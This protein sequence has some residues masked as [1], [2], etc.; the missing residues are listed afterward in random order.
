MFVFFSYSWGTVKI[1]EILYDPEGSDSD[2]EWIEFYNNS[3]SAISLKSWKIYLGG[4]S[5]ALAY[6]FPEVS[7]KA[8]GF[9]VVGFPDFCD[10]QENFAFQ[11][12]GSATDGV[13][14]E[15]SAGV[16]RDVLLYDSPNSNSLAIEDGSIGNKFAPD[17]SSGHSLARKIDGKDSDNCEEDFIECAE[18]TPGK[19]N[20]KEKPVFKK[21]QTMKIS[22]LYYDP[23]GTDGDGEWIELYNPTDSAINLQGWQIYAGGSSYS[24]AYEFDSCLV[25]SKSFAVIGA[26]SEFDVVKKLSFQNGGSETD[27]VK[28][29]SPDGSYCDVLLYDSPNTNGLTDENGKI[30]ENFAEDVSEGYSLARANL[31]V[32]FD[33]SDLDFSSTKFLTPRA[34][35]KFPISLKLSGFYKQNEKLCTKITNLSTF[36]LQAEFAKITL[37]C[38]GSILLEHKVGFVGKN[39]SSEIALD[40]KNS[41]DF[42]QVWRANL[43]CELDAD[44]SDNTLVFSV[45]S[46]DIGLV[47]NEVM[48]NPLNGSPE[49]L[50]IYN[51]GE[52]KLT[53]NDVQLRDK[54]GDITKFSLQIDK[55][56]YLVITDNLSTFVQF[57]PQVDNSKIIE[58]K[59]L[60]SLNNSD[61]VLI[62]E[63]CWG[64]KFDSVSYGKIDLAKGV[65]LE[66][67]GYQDLGNVWGES[68]DTATPGEANSVRVYQYKHYFD[69]KISKKA[70]K[71]GENIT[72][73]Y[74]VPEIRSV[75]RVHCK[76]YDLQGNL[77]RDLRNYKK[78]A[79][80]GN[81]NFDGRDDRGRFLES[82]VYYVVLSVS[83]GNA[84]YKKRWYVTI[85]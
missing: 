43:A 64:T 41:N 72:I 78:S 33:K 52:G 37:S 24:L 76:V 49:W 75:A 3:D 51:G 73:S 56:E 23:P 38:N 17:V 29:S 66:K 46:S 27:G 1:N 54:S 7:I 70:M 21:W 28:L 20:V 45:V 61:E 8:K 50:E 69:T 65:S 57:Y 84:I 58:V 80:Q 18:P 32:D 48:C 22:E 11:N 5:F 39:A 35:N 4:N 12:G 10:L 19:S 44:T 36:D 16:C 68:V 13:K 14:L 40:C 26:N 77:K 47:I 74:N 53:I 67:F 82:G 83:K 30:G 9:L 71:H 62:L 25:A 81:I 60:I 59:N 63:D 31:E 34:K 79:V 15:D 55:G 85:K 2:K 6:T 42:Y